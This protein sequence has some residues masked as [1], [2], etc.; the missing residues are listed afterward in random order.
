MVGE[1]RSVLEYSCDLKDP[2]CAMPKKYRNLENATDYTV[3][4]P[5]TRPLR[6]ERTESAR[7]IPKS[8]EEKHV[9]GQIESLPAAIVPPT[10][11]MTQKDMNE[12]CGRKDS[13]P[14][15][16][17]AISRYPVTVSPPRGLK[18]EYSPKKGYGR[19]KKLLVHQ[20]PDPESSFSKPAN[21]AIEERTKPTKQEPQRNRNS[22]PERTTSQ[23]KPKEE[24]E[25]DSRWPVEPGYANFCLL[26]F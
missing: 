5:G 13:D 16:E 12:S 25:F 1:L 3:K 6:V 4:P 26:V 24:F 14:V 11:E 18:E 22:I 21:K 2:F 17:V 15:R 7:D 20:F 19:G 10:V 23:P 9:L 8:N